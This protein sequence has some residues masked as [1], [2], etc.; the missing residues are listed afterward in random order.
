[1]TI[2]YLT[3]KIQRLRV[4]VQLAV[5]K[6][7]GKIKAFTWRQKQNGGHVLSRGGRRGGGGGS[8]EV[9]DRETM[10]SQLS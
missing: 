3:Q 5:N 2:N 8:D 9:W 10:L 4:H 1:M 6:N 7:G